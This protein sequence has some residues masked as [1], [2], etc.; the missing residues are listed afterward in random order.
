[1]PAPF[2]DVRM[3]HVPTVSRWTTS[4]PLRKHSRSSPN[5]TTTSSSWTSDWVNQS[6]A[7]TSCDVSGPK[8]WTYPLPSLTGIGDEPTAVEMLKAGA[9]DYLVKHS[10]GAAVLER[11]I[12]YGLNQH[13][14]LVA[15]RQAEEALRTSEAHYRSL[16]ENADMFGPSRCP[17][18]LPRAPG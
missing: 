2:V 14:L 6:R 4:S 17:G 10:F 3:A 12:H 13:R 16:V 5:A 15:H 8:Q 7:R 1:M 11:A 18:L 9:T